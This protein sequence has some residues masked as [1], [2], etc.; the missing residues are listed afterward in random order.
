MKKVI[1]LFSL[2]VLLLVGYT[3]WKML[4]YTPH[5]IVVN[6]E[7]F[8]GMERM[9]RYVAISGQA[10]KSLSVP[11]HKNVEPEVSI[12]DNTVEVT[13]PLVPQPNPAGVIVL[14]GDY[15]VKV[16]LIEGTGEVLDVLVP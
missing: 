16:R 6:Y 14:S 3:A 1:V 13:W 7:Q 4:R 2:V 12:N 8:D 11:I 15:Q 10:M 9:E 5:P